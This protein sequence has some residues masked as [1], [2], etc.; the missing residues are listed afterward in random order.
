MG[1]TYIRYRH[2]PVVF[3]LHN[4]CIYCSQ[5]TYTEDAATESTVS[6]EVL[7]DELLVQ[8]ELCTEKPEE[9]AQHQTSRG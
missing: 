4:K 7:E 5:S 6:L 2:N 3:V 9:N 8:K 1:T